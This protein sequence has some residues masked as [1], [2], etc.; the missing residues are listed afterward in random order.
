MT[1][2]DLAT[3]AAVL[4]TDQRK[5]QVFKS[6]AAGL[7]FEVEISPDLADARYLVIKRA[8]RGVAAWLENP[9]YRADTGDYVV[10]ADGKCV[11]IM[12][13]REK[14]LMLTKELLANCA[15]SLPLGDRQQFPRAVRQYPR[16]K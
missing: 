7:S 6:T 5:L 11:G 12:V 3:P 4:Q 15:L 1:T 14:C 8:L 2:M 9:A 16:L 10:T 13:S